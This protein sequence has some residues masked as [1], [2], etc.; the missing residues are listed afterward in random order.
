M[1]DVVHELALATGLTGLV[2]LLLLGSWRS[3]LIIASSIP[4][5]IL[6]SILLLHA[7]GQTINVMTLGGL[8]LAVGILACEVRYFIDYRTSTRT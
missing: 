2:V 6:T 4:L 3:T 8:A 5:A 1:N 7:T